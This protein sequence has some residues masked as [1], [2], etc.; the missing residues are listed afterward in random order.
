VAAVA[1]GDLYE[2]ILEGLCILFTAYLLRSSLLDPASRPTFRACSEGISRGESPSRPC[3]RVSDRSRRPPSPT[4]P[5]LP[6]SMASSPGS[7]PIRCCPADHP[8]SVRRGSTL[9]PGDVPGPDPESTVDLEAIPMV[10]AE[11]RAS[12]VKS[13]PQLDTP[14]LFAERSTRSLGHRPRAPPPRTR[15]GGAVHG[16]R[17]LRSP[18]QLRPEHAFRDGL[19]VTERR[20]HRLRPKPHPKRQVVGHVVAHVVELRTDAVRLKRGKRGHDP[21]CRDDTDDL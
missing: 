9:D 1:V 2:R 8:K 20:R 17:R 13:L 18:M 4:P 14:A 5:A 15:L 12:R 6:E 21:E 3:P 19:P 10:A 11:E 16:A 7:P